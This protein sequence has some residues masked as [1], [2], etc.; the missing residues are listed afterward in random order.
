[1]SA[2][3]VLREVVASR[4]APAL[5]DVLE[6]AA[7]EP[8]PEVLALYS[9]LARRVGKAPAELTPYERE[10]LPLERIGIDELA[11]ICLLLT[12]AQQRSDAEMLQLVDEAW[13]R[14][15]N[16]ERHAI[17]RALPLLPE[18]KQYVPRAVDACR[19]SVQTIFEAIAC[20]NPFPGEH[21]SELAFNQL[22]LKAL[23]TGVA[24][25][26]II[27]LPARITPELRRMARDYASERR[28]AGRTLPPDIGVL[29]N[30][31][32]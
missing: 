23:F 15:D 1:M 5:L 4:T 3:L 28:A 18:P 25:A 7:S 30:E 32:A 29:T 11:R 17:L 14:G 10:V 31:G 19:S 26:R 12:A 21:F 9:G 22:V 24:L 13:R 16:R 8:A 2:A 6:S 20:E 27:G